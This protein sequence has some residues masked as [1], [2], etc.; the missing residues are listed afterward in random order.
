MA[1]VF[2]QQAWSVAGDDNRPETSQAKTQGHKLAQAIIPPVEKALTLKFWAAL[3]SLRITSATSISPD[4]MYTS[5]APL[6]GHTP[7]WKT[8]AMLIL[9]LDEGV[10]ITPNFAL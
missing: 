10:T 4:S 9:H 2:P 8:Q 7:R 5:S 1:G 3:F 6:I